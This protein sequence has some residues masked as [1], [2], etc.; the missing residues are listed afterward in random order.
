MGSQSTSSHRC[1]TALR[2]S[3]SRR[4]CAPGEPARPKMYVDSS[5]RGRSVRSPFRTHIVPSAAAAVA[6]QARVLRAW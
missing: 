6:S 3:S 5:P 4:A 2:A 1:A